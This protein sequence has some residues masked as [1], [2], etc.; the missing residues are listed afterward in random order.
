[1]NIIIKTFDN[2]VTFGKE[3]LLALQNLKSSMDVGGF[4][5]FKK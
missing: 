1:M 5:V 3:F 2:L 4:Q